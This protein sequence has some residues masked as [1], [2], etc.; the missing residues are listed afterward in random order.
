MVK[1]VT[2]GMVL[3]TSIWRG[4]LKMIHLWLWLTCLWAQSQTLSLQALY[5]AIQERHPLWRAIT[6]GPDIAAAQLQA[7][8][9]V[10][11]PVLSSSY[12]AKYFKNQ[13]YYTL[14]NADLKVPIWNAFDLKA[15][16]EKTFGF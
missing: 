15:L 1:A 8:R 12:T 3:V 5:Q 7:T 4:W 14:L 11:D 13:L 9:S 2:G 16:Y 10:W 6:L